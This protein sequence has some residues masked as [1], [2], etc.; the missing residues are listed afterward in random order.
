MAVSIPT[1]NYKTQVVE[2]SLSASEELKEMVE[3][4]DPLWIYDDVKQIQVLNEVE[5][6]RRFAPLDSSLEEIIKVI[7]NGGSIIDEL[8]NLNVDEIQSETKFETEASRAMGIVNMNAHRIAN[9]FMDV[10]QWSLL[11]SNMVSK[12]TNLGRLTQGQGSIDGVVQV[13]NA[14]YEFSSP[15]LKGRD[16]K[17]A[18]YCRQ[19]DSSTW[20]ISDVSLEKVFPNPIIKCQRRPSGCLIQALPDGFSKVT[21]V[22]HNVVSK[23]IVHN[24]FEKLVDSSLVFTSNRWLTTLQRFYDRNTIFERDIGNEWKGVLKLGERMLRSYHSN[25]NSSLDIRWRPMPLSGGEDIL[26]RTNFNEDDPGIPKVVTLNI[27]TSVWLPI[28]QDHL[29]NFFCD[30][31]NRSKWDLLS[32]D[33]VTREAMV[34]PTTKGVDGCV[35]IVLVEPRDSNEVPNTYIQESFRDSNCSYVVYAPIDISAMSYILQGEEADFV[36]ILPSGFSIL[37]GST[38]HVDKEGGKGSIL[39]ISFEIIDESLSSPDVL[40]PSSVSTAYNIIKATI[41]SIK[42]A[43]TAS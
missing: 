43:L 36:A 22:E 21:F 8:P 39:T 32:R 24:M 38:M 31:R 37:P 26:V 16:F 41:V 6:K 18:R 30:G 19:R 13:M 42:H 17:F 10:E 28:H 3:G 14:T 23:D 1:D 35:S 11:F 15:L 5:Y 9:I 40:P 7:T 20:L 4:E 27:A 33:R 34:L 25:V 29:F 2:L 12:A